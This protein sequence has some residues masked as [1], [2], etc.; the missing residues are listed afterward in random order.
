[1]S[2][3]LTFVFVVCL[4]AMSHCANHVNPKEMDAIKQ[5]LQLLVGNYKPKPLRGDDDPVVRT[6]LLIFNF[7][8]IVILIFYNA[9]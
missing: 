4:A 9:T 3:N 2:I 7:I 1:M 8:F 6:I 5:N